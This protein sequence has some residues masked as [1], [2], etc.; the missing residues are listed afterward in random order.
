[1]KKETHP[2]LHPVIFVDLSTNDEFVTR[3]TMKS[4]ESRV[5]DGIEHYVVKCG[6]TSA[7]H[8]VYTGQTRLVDT[9]GR[10]DKFKKR[11]GTLKASE[12]VAAGKSASA[13]A[14]KKKK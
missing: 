13:A 7:S 6:V 3:S 1:M 9:A 8:P 11:F 2:A 4:D 14:K 12:A 10:V 5:I